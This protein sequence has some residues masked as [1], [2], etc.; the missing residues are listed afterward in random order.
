MSHNNK[1]ERMNWKSWLTS[2]GHEIS[3]KRNL[4][5]T[6]DAVSRR[7]LRHQCI[8]QNLEQ[9][10]MLKLAVIPKIFRCTRK[11]LINFTDNRCFRSRG[12]NWSIALSECASKPVLK[13]PCYF[14]KFWSLFALWTFSSDER[15][16]NVWH[17]CFSYAMKSRKALVR[18][19]G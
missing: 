2:P 8:S 6:N 7:L 18:H 4:L 15:V 10:S 12:S 3:N 16:E 1:Q 5:G 9:I 17:R 13:R 14:M 11:H 19:R